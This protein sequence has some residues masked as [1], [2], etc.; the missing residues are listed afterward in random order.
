MALLAVF[1]S[2]DSENAIVVEIRAV[3]DFNLVEGL[4]LLSFLIRVLFRSHLILL[5]FL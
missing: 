5:L 3:R 1:F 4:S 2:G